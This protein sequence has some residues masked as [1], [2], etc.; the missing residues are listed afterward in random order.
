MSIE[1]STMLRWRASGLIRSETPPRRGR[2]NAT[3]ITREQALEAVALIMLRRAGAP[4]QQLAPLV[5]RMRRE[6]KRGRD[7]LTL[8]ADKRAA[9]L[10]GLGPGVPLRDPHTGQMRLFAALDLRKLA[11]AIEGIVDRLAREESPRPR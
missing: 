2:G 3:L 6:G 7:F 1:V 9:L 5:R 8:G 4:M 10:D 11:P